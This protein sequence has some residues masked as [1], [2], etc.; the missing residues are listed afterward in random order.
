MSFTEVYASAASSSSNRAEAFTESTLSPVLA[1][2]QQLVTGL[3]R[4]VGE[5]RS[6]RRQALLQEMEK[7][8]EEATAMQT[9]V[10]A[11][12]IRQ[13]SSMIQINSLT[14]NFR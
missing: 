8:L 13:L 12:V 14:I 1:R 10:Q 4:K 11:E 7:D 9:K 5:Y 6:S 2:L 3:K